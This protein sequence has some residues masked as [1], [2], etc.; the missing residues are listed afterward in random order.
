ME[1]I[2]FPVSKYRMCG[3]VLAN[4]A[5]KF[6]GNPMKIFHYLTITKI[7]LESMFNSLKI[8]CDFAKNPGLYNSKE[9]W[10]SNIVIHNLLFHILLSSIIVY[11]PHR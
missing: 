1:L 10:G 6:I 4:F 9:T 2:K 5:E 11:Y 3:K 8:I 7:L